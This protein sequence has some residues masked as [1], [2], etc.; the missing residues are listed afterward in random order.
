MINSML[1][2]SLAKPVL[3]LT[4]AGALSTAMVAPASAGHHNGGQIVLGIGLG[5]LAGGLL[6]NHN[7]YPHYNSNVYVSDP[8]YDD[9]QQQQSCYRS[10]QVVCTKKY[11]CEFDGYGNKYCQPHRSCYHPVVCN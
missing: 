1:L 3:A 10:N 2:K 8:Y 7:R 11:S 4:L 6:L 5:L 9:E